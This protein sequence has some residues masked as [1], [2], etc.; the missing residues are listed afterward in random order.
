MIFSASI[1]IFNISC[2]KDSDAQPNSNS[3]N[4]IGPQPKFQFKANG[5]LYVCDAIFDN[6]IGWVGNYLPYQ[7]EG[8]LPSFS[9]SQYN[10]VTNSELSGGVLT[11]SGS[12][13]INL[14][15]TLADASVGTYYSEPNSG[16]DCTIENVQY[17]G[18][19]H[20][21]TFTRVSNGTADGTFSGTL[22]KKD[23]PNV[24]ISLT[25]GVFSNIPIFKY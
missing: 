13:F 25:E 11:S 14:Y 22:I 18:S 17:W 1:I 15:M 7:N 9:I 23:S 12:N 20:S 19:T 6:R 21:I 8:G 4:C 2:N 3:S 10:N 24:T 5:K 16:A